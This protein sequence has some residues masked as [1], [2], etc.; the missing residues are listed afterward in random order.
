MSNNVLEILTEEPS[1]ENFLKVILPKI[2][3][4]GYVLGVNCFIRPHEG[5]S[6]LRKSIPIKLKAL[7][8]YKQKVKVL[9]IHDQD[10][11]DCLKLKMDLINLCGKD[12]PLPILIRIA[13]KE[14]ENWYLGDLNAL[15]S[16]YPETK[17]TKYSGSSKFRNPDKVFGSFEIEKM[18]KNFSKSYASREIP[19]YMDLSNNK[20]QSFNHLIKG[21][22]SFLATSSN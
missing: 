6:N 3:P 21:L 18:S 13:C 19:K 17:A 9:I 5:K 7:A 8:Y 22:K 2:L 15:E 11:N 14:L 4:N 12:C 16:V 20:S 1:M 10:S